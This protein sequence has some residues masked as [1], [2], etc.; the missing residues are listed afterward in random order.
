MLNKIWIGKYQ[1][2]N[3]ILNYLHP[4]NLTF[5]TLL[6]SIIIIISN[7]LLFEG[8]LFLSILLLIFLNKESI[9][10][11]IKL[12]K[13][14]SIFLISLVILNILLKTSINI[15]LLTI[16]KTINILFI[17]QIL[18]SNVKLNDLI[19]GISFLLSPLSFFHI[20]IKKISLS[21]SLA[22]HFIPIFFN[23]ADKILRSL[24]SRNVIYK[25]QTLKGKMKMM[26]SI[27]LPLFTNSIK[28]SDDLA[29]TLSI[30]LYDL[31]SQEKIEIENFSYLDKLMIILVCY[32]LLFII[33]K[34]VMM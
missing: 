14:I 3:G 23:Q 18:L 17:S 24:E 6:F 25:K 21:I 31:E 12:I 10:Y 1:N 27:L 33:L 5:L 26:K 4:I 29:D 20:N 15:I 34:E 19:D 13:T 22:L 30:R 2:K 9:E 16:L 7:S 11:Y 8:I 32:L 28:V